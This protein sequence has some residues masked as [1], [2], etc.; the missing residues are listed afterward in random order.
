MTRISPSARLFAL[1]MAAALT[2]SA[3]FAHEPDKGDKSA[4]GTQDTPQAAHSMAG[5]SEGSMEL[6]RIMKSGSQMPMPMSGD[7]DQDFATMMTMHH[8]QA[9]KMSEV[10]LQHGKAPELKELARKMQASQREE[11][12]KMAPHTK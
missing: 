1:C 5:H 6:H 4:K 3:A 8:E 9:I 7:V 11:I 2:T 12:K 10:L